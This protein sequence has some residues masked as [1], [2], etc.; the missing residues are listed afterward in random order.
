MKPTHKLT[1]EQIKEI[2]AWKDKKGQTLPDDESKKVS[3]YTIASIYDISPKTVYNIWNGLYKFSQQSVSFLDTTILKT[4]F[5]YFAIRGIKTQDGDL[6]RE[7][8]VRLIEIS[9]E[10]EVKQK[11]IELEEENYNGV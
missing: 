9:K 7:M 6:T 4:I 11:I 8:M 3:G 2:F 10:P 5:P 1:E